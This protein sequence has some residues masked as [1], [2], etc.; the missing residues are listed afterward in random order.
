[1]VDRASQGRRTPPI[2]LLIGS[3]LDVRRGGS[4]C[5]PAD[6]DRASAPRGI[7]ELDSPAPRNR[8]RHLDPD[9][10]VA[11][12]NG[13]GSFTDLSLEIFF[14]IHKMGSPLPPFFK[15]NLPFSNPPA[16]SSL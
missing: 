9:C 6:L 16:K 11:D 2:A 3:C 12:D 8:G 15:K 4:V 7:A 1:M 5:C 13:G 10:P 14:C